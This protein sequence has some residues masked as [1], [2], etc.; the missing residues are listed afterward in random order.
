MAIGIHRPSGRSSTL[1]VC[2]GLLIVA[3]LGAGTYLRLGDAG[4]AQFVLAG[5]L[6]KALLITAICQLCLYYCDLYDLRSMGDLRHLLVR[7]LQAL[8]ATSMILAFTYFWF[9]SLIIGRGVFLAAAGI[10]IGLIVGWRVAFDWVMTHTAP[11][12]RLLIVGT[13]PAAVALAREL[14]ERRKELGVEIVGF[15]DPDKHMVGAPI[16][17]PGVIGTV[18][19]IPSI[20]RARSVDRVVVSLADARGKLPIDTLLEMKLD[21]GITFDHLPTVY[22]QYTGKI[23]IENLRPS[24]LIFSEGFRKSRLLKTTKRAIDVV[25][26]SA[27]LLVLSPILAAVA[28]LVRLTSAG[29]VFYHQRR[30]GQYGRLFTIRKFR[31]MCVDA[32][33]ETGAVW[34]RQNDTRVTSIGRFLRRT[35]LD[36]L[37]QL[38]NV[39]MGDMSLIGPRPERP[40]FV[41]MLRLKIPF[42][43]MRHVIRPG[44]T[45]WAQ[46]RYTYGATVEDAMEK[47][48]Y[49]LFYLKHLSIALDLVIAFQTAKTVILRR[50]AA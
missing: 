42:Y 11:R 37:P 44:L 6:I 26:A 12:E 1:I 36:E 49:D 20:V 32:E 9:P 38:W 35:R 40:E 14:F 34:A 22:E 29:P 18:E 47:L 46:V 21:R 45:G 5:G 31:S 39:L 3:A 33:A 41:E 13:S 48:Q 7:L 30:V 4:W 8:G 28:A 15:V 27:M 23:A 19:D 2:E 43:G 50:G 25:V 24:W 17:N 10:V 16:L